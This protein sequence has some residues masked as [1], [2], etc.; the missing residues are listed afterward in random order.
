[1]EGVMREQRLRIVLGAGLA[2]VFSL[3]SMSAHAEAPKAKPVNVASTTTAPS[4]P[5]ATDGW[6]VMQPERKDAKGFSVVKPGERADNFGG[7][8]NGSMSQSSGGSMA[9][10]S[11]SNLTSVSRIAMPKF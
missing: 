3:G 7:N 8:T 6:T 9:S 2:A 4:P 5:P 10:S 1:M 11:N